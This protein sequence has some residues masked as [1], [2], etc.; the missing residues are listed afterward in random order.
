[1]SEIENRKPCGAYHPL[2]CGLDTACPTPVKY[3]D[4]E[5]DNSEIVSKWRANHE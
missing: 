4:A 1:M 3:H 2:P 5:L